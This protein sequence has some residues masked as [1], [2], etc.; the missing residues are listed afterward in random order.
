MN[1]SKFTTH[2]CA[3]GILS[4]IALGITVFNIT[5]TL[6]PMQI[7]SVYAV[8]VMIGVLITIVIQEIKGK[9]RERREEKRRRK[10]LL[11]L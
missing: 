9:I 1:V 4:F 11:C 7:I 6:T 5:L 3:I 10:V 8:Y 2:L